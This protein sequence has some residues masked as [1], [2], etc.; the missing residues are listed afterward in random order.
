MVWHSL[1]ILS[2]LSTMTCSSWVAL[3]SMAHRFIELDKAVVRVILML[4]KIESRRR[5]GW[6][7]MRWLDGI[8]DLVYMIWV[9][10]GSWWGTVM[11]R[12]LQSMGLQSQTRLSDW[13]ELIVILY[14]I[15]WE[16]AILFF[17]AAVPFY[18]PPT[19]NR[20]LIYLYPQL[21]FCFISVTVILIGV[22]WY[23]IVVLIYISLMVSDIEHT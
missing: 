14:L 18:I 8:T 20:V 3:H 1:H 10:S 19:V 21:H 9:R 16:I 12:I 5:R 23:F 4:E 15:L 11:P 22:R 2:E 7:R 6:Q 13:T 17:T